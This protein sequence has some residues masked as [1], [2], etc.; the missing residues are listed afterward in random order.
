MVDTEFDKDA[1]DQRGQEGRGIDPKEVAV[2]ALKALENDEFEAT[3][4]RAQFLR[5]GARNE[6]ERI[7]QRM[8]G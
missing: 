3:V 1:R 7:F 6:P 4:G 5:M 8:N 2:A